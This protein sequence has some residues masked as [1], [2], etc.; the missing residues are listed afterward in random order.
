MGINYI[1]PAVRPEVFPSLAQATPMNI[2]AMIW[3]FAATAFTLFLIQKH[4]GAK[5]AIL[6]IVAILCEAMMFFSPT[7][8]ASGERVFYVTDWIL[9][10]IILNQVSKIPSEKRKLIFFSLALILTILNE[11]TQASELLAKLNGN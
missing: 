4:L 6:F 10:F 9:V 5:S 3:W 8:Y 11:V 7:I 2:L 1:D